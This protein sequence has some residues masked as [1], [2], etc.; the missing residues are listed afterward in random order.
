[1]NYY[2][3]SSKGNIG[4]G[5]KTGS[6]RWLELAFQNDQQTWIVILTI[7]RNSNFGRQRGWC[8]LVWEGWRTLR[9][10]L[11]TQ[12]T[13]ATKSLLI[14]KMSSARLSTFTIHLRHPD[15]G[16]FKAKV[17]FWKPWT[18]QKKKKSTEVTK[19]S[20]SRALPISKATV[21]KKRGGLKPVFR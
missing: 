4:A 20:L 7:L 14:S 5:K 11:S 17:M 19:W 1:M 2:N 9:Y 6:Q 12:K 13:H 10:K 21:F 8:F 18:L 3:P 16:G 15:P